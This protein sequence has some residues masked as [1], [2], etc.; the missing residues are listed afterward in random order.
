MDNIIM[1]PS[2]IKWMAKTE[3]LNRFFEMVDNGTVYEWCHMT[4]EQVLTLKCVFNV[5]QCSNIGSWEYIRTSDG[6][7]FFVNGELVIRFEES[8]SLFAIEKIMRKP[9]FYADPLTTSQKVKLCF[10]MTF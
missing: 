4:P 5:T 3:I 9:S 8:P 10:L 1:H 6:G 2:S 7:E